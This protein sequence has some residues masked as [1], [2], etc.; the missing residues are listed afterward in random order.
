MARRLVEAGC[1]V[2][3][4][5]YGFWDTHGGNF[6]YLKQHLPLFD[7][8][9]SA[10]V[11]DIYARGLERRRDGVRLGRVRPHAEDQQG[12]RPRPLGARELRAPRRRRDED[13]AR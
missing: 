5:A 11:E 13:R 2:V 4:V 10:L 6:K 3:T 1:R 7:T 12:R 8:G 9:I